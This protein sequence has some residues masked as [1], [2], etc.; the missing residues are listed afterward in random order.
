M[1]R[2]I[3]HSMPKYS[4]VCRNLL[5][6]GLGK[7]N[8]FPRQT[9]T[10][11][12]THWIDDS[13]S[14]F[15]TMYDY[16][17]VLPDSIV[18]THLQ[19]FFNEQL[20]LS[21]SQGLVTGDKKSILRDIWRSDQKWSGTYLAWN[22]MWGT[23]PAN[24]ARSSTSRQ[25]STLYVTGVWCEYEQISFEE[26][27][28]TWASTPNVLLS[29]CTCSCPRRTNPS[30]CPVSKFGTYISILIHEHLDNMVMTEDHRNLS[31]KITTTALSTFKWK[32]SAQWSLQ[33]RLG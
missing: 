14:L 3:F 5:V 27:V 23:E 8:Y 17:L 9:W 32:R 31:R 28:A 7:C 16:N 12:R 20:L 29:R 24:V 19:R 25:W 11:R 22:R 6:V 1:I 2:E 15:E 33:K 13:Q 18:H 21:F 4:T 10:L 26:R 30:P